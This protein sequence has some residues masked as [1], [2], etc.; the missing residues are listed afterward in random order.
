MKRRHQKKG[1]M[2]GLAVLVLVVLVA[3][4]ILWQRPQKEESKSLPAS[5]NTEALEEKEESEASKKET[6]TTPDSEE[7]DKTETVHVQA[8]ATGNVQEITVEARLRNKGG[9]GKISD[10]SELE[11]IKNTKGDEEFTQAPDGTLLWENHGE[12]IYYEGKSQKEL[13]VNVKVSYY[14]EGQQI[15]PQELAGKSGAVRIRLDYENHTSQKVTVEDKELEMPVPFGVFSAVML[16]EDVFSN[17]QVK[18]GKAMDMEGQKIVLGYAFPGLQENLKLGEY[19]PTEELEIPDYVEI[20]AD[21]TD[22]ALDFTATVVTSGIFEDLDTKDLEEADELTESSDEMKDASKEL[23]DGAD[24]LLDGLGTFRSYME[25]YTTGVSSASDGSKALADGLK[26]L[27][28]KKAEVLSGAEALQ[29]GL[30]SLNTA[31]AEISLPKSQGM[32]GMEE[33]A[34]ALAADAQTVSVFLTSLQETLEKT[35]SFCGEAR[36]YQSQVDTLLHTVREQLQGISFAGAEQTATEMARSQARSALMAALA[37]TELSEEEKARIC[38]STAAG[39]QISGIIQTAQEQLSQAVATLGNV[40]A[41]E[42]P[43]IAID[44]SVYQETVTDMQ[45][46]LGILEQYSAALSGMGESFS[47]MSTAL[48]ALKSGTAKLKSGSGQLTEGI[49]AF[50]QGIEKVYEGAVALS[51]G[52]QQ[53]QSAGASLGTGLDTLTEGMRALSE[54]LETF[55]EEGI[56][57]LAELA[58]EDLENLITRVKAMKE[59]DGLYENYSGLASGQSGSVKFIIETE[60]IEKD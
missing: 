22:F 52:T 58:G 7:K 20:T 23:M 50:N 25:Q 39:I 46:Q 54:G 35:D 44:S 45:K 18:N 56:Q 47:G 29:E 53:L 3:L 19:E 2:I 15:N 16:P 34:N 51:G 8:D 21:V 41:L 13:P 28:E 32:E 24:K 30:E 11:E 59:A 48:T 10:Y 26:T 17:V 27:N 14:L 36:A 4:A 38:D 31:L 43:E 9:S 37:G 55:D 49:E 1:R 57:K 5:Q 40:P 42:I 60:E 33:A 12:D 6:E